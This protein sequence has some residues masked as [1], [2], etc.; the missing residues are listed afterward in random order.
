MAGPRLR[1]VLGRVLRIQR[2]SVQGARLEAK[3]VVVEVRP[4]QR[5]PRCGV[6]G[7]PAPGYDASPGRLWRHLALGQTIFWLHYAP[8]RVHCREH[9]V[10]VERVPW[11]AHDSRDPPVH[12]GNAH[13]GY[14]R[15]RR[16]RPPRPR[17]DLKP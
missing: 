15:S 17:T 8:R 2:L 5:K 1:E 9:G 11:A 16:G 13:F 12:G 6:C 10:R 7:R 14:R 3:G 4:C